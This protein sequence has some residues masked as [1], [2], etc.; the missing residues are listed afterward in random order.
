MAQRIQFRRG[1]STQWTSSNPILAEGEMGVELDT[2]LFK[3]GNGVD[4]WNDLYYGGLNPDLGIITFENQ[5]SDPSIPPA[6]YARLWMNKIG[7]RMIPRFLGNGGVDSALQPAF[8]GNG[9]QMYS[10][11]TSTAPNVLGGP[12]LTSVG[13]VSHPA[14]ASTNLRTQTSRWQVVSAATANSAAENRVAFARIWRGDSAGLGG[15]F[16][17]TRFSIT[18]Q[19]P[20]QRSLFGFTSSTA[21]TATTTE[22]STLLN[23]FGIGNG[24]SETNLSVYSNDASGTAY[25]YDLGS[26]FPSND[27]TAVFDFTVFHPPHGQSMFWEARNLTTGVKSNGEINDSDLPV[28]TT[29]LAYHAYMNN[30]GTASAVSFDVMRIYT[31]TDY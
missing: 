31:E 11:G 28:S 1:N 6:G 13:T 18:S 15:F 3:I 8:F 10:P 30:G 7:G 24:L 26:S 12:T 5:V 23:F 29:F 22:P 17:R 16:H 9:I 2:S 19:V 14:L 21:A 25:S 27:P 20:T 4:N